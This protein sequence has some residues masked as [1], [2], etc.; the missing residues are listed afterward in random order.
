MLL[1]L[2]LLLTIVPAIELALLIHVHGMFAASYGAF[3]GLIFTIGTIVMTGIIGANLAR[4]QGFEVVRRLQKNMEQGLMPAG[5]IQ[6]GLMILVGGALLLTPGY[7]TDTFGFLLLLPF[8]RAVFKAKL[9]AWLKRQI[10]SGAVSFQTSGSFGGSPFGQSRP[11]HSSQTFGAQGFPR[12]NPRSRP[13]SPE[14]IDAE[15]IE[16]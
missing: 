1:R 11:P 15:V 7:L 9:S 10:E 5:E 3:N 14:I 8:S 2:M 4:Q 6:D 13:Q 16:D 12:S